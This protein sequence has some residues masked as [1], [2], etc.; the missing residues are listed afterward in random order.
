MQGQSSE[1]VQKVFLEPTNARIALNHP[2]ENQDQWSDE[3]SRRCRNVTTNK[4]RFC[5]INY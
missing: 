4:S 5:S 1:N 3:D 2:A